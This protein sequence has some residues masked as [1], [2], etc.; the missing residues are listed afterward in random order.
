VSVPPHWFIPV[1]A[2]D[3]KKR[4]K[5]VDEAVS[6]HSG[7][8]L[9][10]FWKTPD[11]DQLFAIIQSNAVNHDLLREIGANGKPIALEDV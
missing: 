8:K 11:G 10:S 3:P 2:S 9:Q 1:R 5:D 4:K 6:Q 7:A